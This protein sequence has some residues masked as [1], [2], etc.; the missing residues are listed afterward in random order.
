MPFFNTEG[1]GNDLAGGLMG[2][3]MGLALEGHNDRR[4]LRQQE[5][6]QR[7]QIA[8]QKE[9]MDYG[10]MKQFDMWLKTNYSEQVNQL[11]KAGLNPALL[12]G[13]GGPGGVTGSASG[14]VQGGGAP[15]GGREIMDIMNLTMQKQMMAAQIKLA[16]AQAN[17]TNVEA[18]KIGGVDTEQTIAQTQLLAQGLDNMREDY[19]IKRLQQTMMQIENFEKQTSQEDRLEQIHTATQ[20]AIRQLK[21]IANQETI[22]SE[23]IQEQIKIIKQTAIGAVLQNELTQNNIKLTKE[24]IE[25]IK[26]SLQQ[27]W[28]Q[29]GLNQEQ[30]DINKRSQQSVQKL[31]NLTGGKMKFDTIIDIV[32][33]LTEIQKA[34]SK[35][36]NLPIPG[37]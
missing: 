30:L 35:T 9:M 17:K 26:Q 23:T 11:K 2:P 3:I 29:L 22:S 34:A 28:V 36:I 37:L 7:L 4:Q 25:K 20:T 18:N 21:I 33:A 5:E 12:Y 1:L 8:G 31:Q 13:K 16:E 10:M 6:L 15:S 27:D 14:S 32:R 19:Q 24:E